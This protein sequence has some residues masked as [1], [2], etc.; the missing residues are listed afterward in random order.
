VV[1]AN[2]VVEPLSYRDTV[3][4]TTFAATFS[5]TVPVIVSVAVVTTPPA[6]VIATTGVPAAGSLSMT[7]V[8]ASTV[9]VA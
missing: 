2:A 8:V 3:D 5:D 6:L 4:P 7:V 9:G 1:V